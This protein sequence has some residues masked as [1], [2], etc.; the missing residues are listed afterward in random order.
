M[1]KHIGALR[2]EAF[3][4]RADDDVRGGEST[5]LFLQTGTRRTIPAR[6]VGFVE[7]PAEAETLPQGSQALQVGAITVHGVDGFRNDEDHAIQGGLLV[8]HELKC[9]EVIMGEA[10][11]PGARGHDA[12]E[13]ARVDESVGEDEV[14]LFR[15]AAEDGGVGREAGVHY[16]PVRITLPSGEGVLEFLVNLG[17]TGDERRS[18][19]RRTPFLER[20]HPGG[21]D[22]GVACE[23]EVI[24]ISEID[25][26]VGRSACGQLTA[27]RRPF[28]LGEGLTQALQQGFVHRGRKW[29]RAD[30]SPLPDSPSSG[31]QDSARPARFAAATSFEGF[32]IALSQTPM[33]PS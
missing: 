13:H 23:A 9:I 30:F 17:V 3:T 24:V 29:K 33:G 8:Q 21:D 25:T 22:R 31:I 18:G 32:L 27:Q 7:Y 28:A 11:E 5:L 2:A 15:Q 10:T 16:E 4:E 12:V 20:S 6:G 1:R 26:G 19:R 14:S